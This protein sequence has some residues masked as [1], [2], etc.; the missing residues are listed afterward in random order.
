MT[1]GGIIV[2]LRV[3]DKTGALGDV[4]LGYDSLDGYLKASPYFGAIIGRYGNRIALGRFTIDGTTFQ[5]PI[6]NPPNSLPGGIRG[7]ARRVWEADPFRS[8]G[9]DLR[10]SWAMALRERTAHIFRSF[11]AVSANR[12]LRRLAIAFLFWGL[13]R[14]ANRIAIYIFAFERGGVDETGLVAL[15][16]LVPSAIEAKVLRE[17]L[18]QTSFAVSHDETRYALNGVL[19]AFQGK[20]VRMVATDGHR[21]ARVEQHISAI[22]L[23]RDDA[24]SLNERRGAPA[25]RTLRVYF[26]DKDR[27]L[28][29]SDSIHPGD[30]FAYTMNLRR[31]PG[32]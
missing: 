5:L 10:C 19:F 32:A 9:P 12:E 29:A 6:N 20:D 16:M 15:V 2:S 14:W 4:V 30:R 13:A 31:G 27:V 8:H 18:T 17:M 25:L 23:D 24:V 11:R 1:Y 28:E 3:P 22:S 21:L 26:D 7:F